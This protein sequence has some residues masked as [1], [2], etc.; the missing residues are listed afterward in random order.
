V[1]FNVFVKVHVENSILGSI[2]VYMDRVQTDPIPIHLVNTILDAT[3]RGCDRP[4]CEA[5]SATDSGVAHAVL[6]ID[7]C[8]RD[9]EDHD[10]CY[11]AGRKLYLHRPGDGRSPPDR[12][13]ALFLCPTRLAHPRRYNCQ[14]DLV[15]RAVGEL[16]ARGELPAARRTWQLNGSACAYVPNS[17]ACATAGRYIASFRTPARLKSPTAPKMDPRWAFSTTCTSPAPGQPA[18]APG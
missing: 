13:P 10:P 3:G 18:P 8:N 12:L 15:V 5:L 14:P 9:W 11:R 16:V 2:L 7:R 1:I 4:E 17:T 6:T